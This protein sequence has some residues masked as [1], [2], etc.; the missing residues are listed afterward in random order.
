LMC[1]G[2]LAALPA[3]SATAAPTMS[4]TDNGLLG[5]NRQWLVQ[6]AADP[7]LLVNGE[8]A[9]AFELGFEV[10]VGELLN[11]SVNTSAWPY[12]LPANNSPPGYGVSPGLTV[13]TM[14]DRVF[15]VLGSDPLNNGNMV[16]VLTIVT[17][18]AGETT[19]TWGGYTVPVPGNPIGGRIAQNGTVFNGYQGS[20]TLGGTMG[21]VWDNS[22]ANGLW[23]DAVNWADDTEPTP[24][25]AVTFPAGFPN[26]GAVVT[27]FAGET[28]ASLTFNDSYTLSGGSL[29]LPA[30]ATVSVA[31]TKT[32]T[33]T[34]GL[35]VGT[36]TKSGDGTLVVPHVRADAL[37]VG[38][39]AVVTSTG[40]GASVL[41]ALSIAGDATPTAKLDLANNAAILNYTGVSPAAM[42]RAQ[43]LAGRG[44]SGLGASW[45]GQGIASS[46]VAAANAIDSESRSIGYAENSALPLGPYLTFHGETVDDTSILMAFTR[47]GDAN[48][49]GVVN[50]DD[51]TIL[52]AFYA[53]GVA[54]P[55]WALGDFDYNGFVD[56]DDVT[57]LGA[58][59]DPSA[60]P[61]M[62]TPAG[63]AGP[64]AA[65]PEP[66]T[67]VLLGVML[68]ASAMVLIRR[69]NS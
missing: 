63:V 23:S 40:G 2:F 10:T 60:P 64:V 41:G 35:D 39:G 36:W 56:D 62:G 11:A 30:G 42:V 13:N 8:G 34:S 47:T 46:A 17:E 67:A 61:I 27:L 52:S 7:A 68:V 3:T 37:T 5:G 16:P 43:V 21:E 58:F 48:L 32:A 12:D 53:P 14:T 49:D 9:L 22:S 1:A 44:G 54:N 69:R 50:D 31:S 38:A 28:A 59:Y 66:A 51:V 19:L 45:N 18:G 4:V 20:L 25:S 65:V 29:T 15:A 6:V 24:G 33:I 55:N 57:L 26:G